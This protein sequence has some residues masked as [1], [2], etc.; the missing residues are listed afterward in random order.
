VTAPERNP[1]PQIEAP[2][3]EQRASGNLLAL[4]TISRLI[5]FNLDP[6]E[7]CDTVVRLLQQRF[8]YDRVAIATIEAAS[9]LPPSEDGQVPE[10]AASLPEPIPWFASPA[11]YRPPPPGET[12]DAAE[13]A[14]WRMVRRTENGDNRIPASFV[15]TG[16]IVGRTTRTGQAELIA[17]VTTDPDYIE[18][19][20]GVL[21]QISVPLIQQQE[22]LGTLNVESARRR[23]DEHD[24]ALLQT[25]ADV[26]V[27]ALHNARLYQQTQR[28][29]DSARRAAE[30]LLKLHHISREVLTASR[31]DE[32]LER[33]TS[34]AL[35]ISGGIYASLHMP[36]GQHLRLVAPHTSMSI[37]SEG[38]GDFRPE[39]GQGIIG[40]CFARGEMLVVD[41]TR[42]DP[43]IVHRSLVAQLPLRSLIALPL[44]VQHQT[45]GVLS[46]GHMAPAS[47]SPELRQAL[48]LLSDQA[49]ISIRRAWLDEELRQ[50][51]ERATDLDQLKD[52]FL[53]MASHE[54]RTPLTAVMGFL[55]LLSDYPGPLSD[56]VAQRFLNRARTATDELT[57]L[58]GNILDGTRGELDRSK[59]L[60]EQIELAA[61][62]QRV[63]PLITARARHKLLARVPEGLSVWVDEMKVQQVLLNLLAN[64]IKYSPIDTAIIID[65]QREPATDMV[66]I[67]VR[68]QGPGI[69]LEDQPRLFQKFV[70]LNEGINSAVRGTGLGLYISRL[71]VEGMNGQIGLHSTPGQ[72]S[73]F[74]F[75][76]PTRPPA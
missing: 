27:V 60:F 59:L 30:L 2:G 31:L 75:S 37:A 44:I 29:R 7:L 76:L 43:R 21:S 32:T 74:W 67:S 34:A 1:L 65:A 51:L 6:Q 56:E 12:P 41:D 45:L 20:P 18:L 47:F 33:I 64:A 63:L 23:L 55:E 36:D 14:R 61:L 10:V 71:L 13:L 38:I 8:G 53:L 48:A 58:L 24:F 11:L 35:E 22:V 46:V 16:G 4:S 49:A 57:L 70:R 50:A 28:E 25:V 15:L 26:M 62:V 52:H 72:G 54:L 3:K 42:I 17:D 39:I 73:T 68:D 9:L 40:L 69:P 66:T 5:N 19:M